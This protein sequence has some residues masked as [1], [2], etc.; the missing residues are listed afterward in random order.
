MRISVLAAALL[1]ILCGGAAFADTSSDAS[2]GP[3]YSSGIR[4]GTSYCTNFSMDCDHIAA[5][6]SAIIDAA[7]ECISTRFGIEK[8]IMSSF[9][10]TGEFENCVLPQGP[11]TNI[12]GTQEWAVCCV[13]KSDSG[14][15]EMSCTRYISQKQ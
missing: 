2:S 7:N 9:G 14:A 8:R 5:E 6:K 12:R 10:G 11:N 15:C 3:F 1:F 13:K 4:M